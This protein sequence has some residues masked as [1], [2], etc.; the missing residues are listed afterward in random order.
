MTLSGEFLIFMHTYELIYTCNL[1]YSLLFS[2]VHHLID[3]MIDGRFHFYDFSGRKAIP[4][5]DNVN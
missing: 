1:R 3:R 5:I 4:D 2:V